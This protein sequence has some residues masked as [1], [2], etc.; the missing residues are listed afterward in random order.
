[1]KSKR[2]EEALQKGRVSALLGV[3]SLSD[4]EA[5]NHAIAVAD[6]VDEYLEHFRDEY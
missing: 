2:L 4:E 5:Y 1:M 3:L 6:I